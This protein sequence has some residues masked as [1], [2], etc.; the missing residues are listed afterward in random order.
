MN[1]SFLK[2]KDNIFD[3]AKFTYV[4]NCHGTERMSTRGYQRKVLTLMQLPPIC[5]NKRNLILKQP[6]QS[7]S[8]LEATLFIMHKLLF[9]VGVTITVVSTKMERSCE[10]LGKI[11]FSLKNL[12]AEWYNDGLS[13]KFKKGEIK[14]TANDSVII[15]KSYG[16]LDSVEKFRKDYL[17]TP[18]V[19]YMFLD[20]FAFATEEQQE[21]M[22]KV[23]FPTITCGIFNKIIISSAT[24][25]TENSFYKLC[26][27]AMGAKSPFLM[28]EIPWWDVYNF[29]EGNEKRADQIGARAWMRNTDCSSTI[30]KIDFPT[31]RYR[32]RKAG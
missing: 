3:L 30:T 32:S 10:I 29:N 11:A 26:V 24:N 31:V 17:V 2:C 20:D 28:V 18:R 21:H 25:G 12:P 14:N 9:E 4:Q 7:G 15:A 16:T 27:E 5:G 23:I 6:R 1:K 22:V 8:T 13:I 19:N